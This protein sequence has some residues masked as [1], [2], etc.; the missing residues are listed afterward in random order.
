LGLTKLGLRDKIAVDLASVGL[1]PG[2]EIIGNGRAFVIDLGILAEV[3]AEVAMN[4]LVDDAYAK[5][6]SEIE[7]YLARGDGTRCIW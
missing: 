3:Y 5:Y 2:K 6:V 7:Q 4:Q 1:R